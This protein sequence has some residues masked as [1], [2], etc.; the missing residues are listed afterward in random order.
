MKKILVVLCLLLSMSIFAEY[1]GF[2][3]QA[4]VKIP[5]L[6]IKKINGVYEKTWQLK[7]ETIKGY[8][9]TVCCYPCQAPFGKAYQSWL[10]VY[11]ASDKKTLWKIPVIVDGG[12]FGGNA[13]IEQITDYDCISRFDLTKSDENYVKKIKKS[14]FMMNTEVHKTSEITLTNRKELLG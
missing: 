4:V 10:Y 6:E 7:T 13:V 3:Y 12:L 1:Q 5:K 11:K 9:V 8:L 14:W 2:N